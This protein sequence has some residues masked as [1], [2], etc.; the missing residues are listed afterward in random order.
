MI[1]SSGSLRFSEISKHKSVNLSEVQSGDVVTLIGDFDP[2]SI[3]TLLQL[4]DKK[5]ILIPLTID[6]RA[7]HEYF[8]DSALV[9]IIIEGD[10]VRRISHGREHKLIKS[11]RSKEH[12]G[13]VLF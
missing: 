7:Q 3:Q 12:A 8:F 2:Q 11:L 13:L 4:I 9:D 10:D 5:V 6:T 1:H